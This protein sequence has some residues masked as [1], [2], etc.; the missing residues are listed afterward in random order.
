MTSILKNINIA[1]VGGGRF[2][3]ALLEALFDSENGGNGTQVLGVADPN[4]YAV[5]R[6]YAKKNGIFTTSDY[7]ELY[8]LEGLRLIVELTK[9]IAVGEEIKRSK[10]ASVQFIDFFEARALLDRLHVKNKKRDIF[11]KL[12]QHRDD[13]SKIEALFD[14]FYTF[15][16]ETSRRKDTYTLINRKEILAGE[17]ALAQIVQ[18]STIPTFVINKS[19]TVTHWNRACEK[20]TG[21]PA[22]EIIGTRQHWKPFRPEKRPIMAD[23]IL[24]GVSEEEVWRY[25]G[26]KWNRSELIQGAFEAEEYFDH[27]GENG[28][29]LFFTAAPIK[30]AEGLVIGAIETLWDKTAEKRAQEERERH[31][32]ELKEKAR[33]LAASHEI[34][35]QIIQGS[36]IP[37][38]VIDK[39][40]TIIHW[41]K[42]LEN[43]TGCRG[44]EMVGTNKQWMPFW[45]SERPA[46]ADVILDQTDEREIK[47]LYG[48]KWRKSAL[49]DGAYEAEI[50]FPH[51][52]ENGRWCF[53]TAAPIRSPEGE[54]IGAIETLWDKSEEK[55]AQFELDRHNRELSQQTKALL[56]SKEAMAQII[57]G[58]TIP[59][60]VIDRDHK[61]THWNRACEKLTGF[62]AEEMVGTRKQWKPFRLQERPVMAD[63]VLDG[64]NEEEVWRY[65]STRWKKSDLIRGAYEAE[66]F[67]EHMGDEG[68]WLFFTAA[69]LTDPDGTV[70]GAI[71]TLWDKTE[72]KH[73]EQ[74]QARHTQELA[75][76]CSIYS[77]LSAPLD[78]Q[79]RIEEALKEI[80]NIFAF[81]VI[82]V[83]S[84]EADGTYQL[85]YSF[86]SPDAVCSIDDLENGESGISCISQVGRS[87]K[88]ALFEN[89]DDQTDAEIE[90]LKAA[91]LNSLVYIPLVGKENKAIGVIR[92]GSRNSSQFH[93]GEKQI[94]ELTGN[95]IGVAMENATL[96]EEIKRRANF[97]A[98]LIHS[99][100]NGIVATD[101][102]WNIVMY[103]P[104]AQ[105]LFGFAADDVVGA[106]DARD[107][108][109]EAFITSIQEKVENRRL[110]ELTTWKE[111]LIQSKKGEMIPV[112]F[113][114]APLFEKGRMM[115]SVAFFQDIREIKNLQREL[116]NAERL[117]AVGQTVAGMAH[118]IKNILNGFKGGRYL[119][120]IGIDKNNVDKLKNGWDMIKRNIDQTSE[121][122][123]DLLSYS[124]EREPEYKPCNPSEIADDVCELVRGNAQDYE[125]EIVKNFS[126]QIGEVILDPTTVHRALLNL[127]GN[128]IDA[129]IFDDSIDKKH[130]VHVRTR[131]EERFV[132]LEVEDNGCGMDEEVK[133]KLFSS[134]FSTKGA[135]GTGLGLLVTHKLIEENQGEIDVRSTVGEGTTFTIRLPFLVDE[136]A[137]NR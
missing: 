70:V 48:S 99:S 45:D 7:K 36:T 115:G 58:S 64:V 137:T 106:M 49:I 107:L 33:E 121:L 32:I 16:V 41:N 83:F 66:E 3:K 91:G 98:K 10:P 19:H 13:F 2:C 4:P 75:T 135:K 18:G 28:K 50:F 97:Q 29:W 44:E 46:M 62:S 132:V 76:L 101:A 95:R 69:P 65:Y 119:V 108:L 94:L 128:A 80:T 63:L 102:D 86:G 59:T 6:L 39:T 125:I 92:A 22:T 5:G 82:C 11:E 77:T 81:D 113:S 78:L 12:Q 1:I 73:A 40:H 24:D 131:L 116:L 67:F 51:L 34:M 120:D 14:E 87:G 103:N 61:V 57:Q 122:V 42:A 30:N 136:K 43:L 72:E 55:N 100:N 104:E 20:L 124:K 129:C 8:R 133:E 127:V 84:L 53:F 105:R 23:L 123:M 25:Y 26:A 37:T 134:F 117:A 27:L 114:C 35:A 109:P 130:T 71:E 56:A 111:A 17:R 38:F 88:L 9:D 54:I 110:A 112:N 93:T 85:K 60:F 52:G 47:N 118:G 68:K 31:N 15:I 89:L 126:D 74:E 90:H 21:Y 79:G 96:Q